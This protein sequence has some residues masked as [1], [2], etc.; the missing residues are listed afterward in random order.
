MSEVRLT[1]ARTFELDP[2]KVYLIQVKREAIS[3]EDLGKLG[4]GLRKLNIKNIV[5]SLPKRQHLKIT[6]TAKESK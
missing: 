2:K 4:E 6:E 3:L 5:V 1:K